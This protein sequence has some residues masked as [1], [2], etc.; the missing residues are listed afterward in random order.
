MNHRMAMCL[1]VF[2]PTRDT[3]SLCSHVRVSVKQNF[4]IHCGQRKPSLK[5]SQKIQTVTSSS[6]KATLAITQT[7]TNPLLSER[8]SLICYVDIW[9]PLCDL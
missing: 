3:A 9:L 1:P 6:V 4:Q 5:L 7:P 8:A 2:L